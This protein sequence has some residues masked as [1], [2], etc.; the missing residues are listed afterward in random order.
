MSVKYV[1]QFHRKR[2]SEDDHNRGGFKMDQNVALPQ[3]R[4]VQCSG[5][6]NM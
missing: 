2:V 6:R 3:S 1:N 4:A 5:E